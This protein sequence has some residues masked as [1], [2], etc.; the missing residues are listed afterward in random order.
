MVSA[1]RFV[2]A[3]GATVVD[4]GAAVTAFLRVGALRDLSDV[5]LGEGPFHDRGRLDL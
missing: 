4:V 2:G 1:G 5:R 3:A